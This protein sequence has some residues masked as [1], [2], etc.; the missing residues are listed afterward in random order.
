MMDLK[1]H[2]ERLYSSLNDVVK[3]LVTNFLFLCIGFEVSVDHP[4]TYVVKCAQLVKGKFN[5]V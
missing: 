5:L 3:V 1:N 2:T 4:N